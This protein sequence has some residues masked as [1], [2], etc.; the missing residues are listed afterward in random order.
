ML[1]MRILGHRFKTI[2]KLLC[3]AKVHS[4]L[5]SWNHL[6]YENVNHFLQKD[7]LGDEF[8]SIGR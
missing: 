1:L 6:Y 2:R 4:D 7:L 3:N 5:G 8:F